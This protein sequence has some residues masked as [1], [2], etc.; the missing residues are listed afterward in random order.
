VVAGDLDSLGPHH[1]T[2]RRPS[3]R[4]RV[5]LNAVE[6]VEQPPAGRVRR[7]GSEQFGLIG[8]DSDVGDRRRTVGDRDRQVEQDPARVEAGSWLT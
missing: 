2:R 1:L 4:D 3:R 8:Q 5:Q 6:L 7:D